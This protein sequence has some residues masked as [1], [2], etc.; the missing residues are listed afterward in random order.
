MGIYLANG[1]RYMHAPAPKKAKQTP[2]LDVNEH[3][4]NKQNNR[5]K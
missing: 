1:I 5:L 2:G 4:R 3:K